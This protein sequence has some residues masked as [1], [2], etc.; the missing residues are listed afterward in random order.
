MP[1][2]LP[3]VCD[4]CGKS[5]SRKCDLNRHA[6]T[7][8]PNA[9]RHHCAFPGCEYSTLQKS[10][11]KTH[12]IARH[13]KQKQFQCNFGC[14]KAYAD[15]AALIRHEKNIHGHFRKGNKPSAA[16]SAPKE[17][18]KLEQP[19]LTAPTSLGDAFWMMPSTPSLCDSSSLAS[20]PTSSFFPSTPSTASMSIASSPTPF[21]SLDLD[22]GAEMFS[23]QQLVD[24]FFHE[25][26]PELLSVPEFLQGSSSSCTTSVLEGTPSLYVESA[27]ST[28][29]SAYTPGLSLAQQQSWS[30][31]P[32]IL[33]AYPSNDDNNNFL[34]MMQNPF[35]DPLH[36][37]ALFSENGAHLDSESYF[38]GWS[39]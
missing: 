23:Q 14:D 6:L 20:S 38:S 17:S 4:E 8:N 16:T 29:P 22:F 1:R 36:F 39:F 10:N 31:T 24:Q 9:T 30:G 21:G 3:F 19:N 13:L 28:S 37:P 35:C 18:V 5:F 34:T 33:S 25:Q 2:V 15:A 27:S 26:I 32:Y 12:Y 7:H 11:V